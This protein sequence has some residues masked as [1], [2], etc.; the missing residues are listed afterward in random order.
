MPLLKRPKPIVVESRRSTVETFVRNDDKTHKF[1]TTRRHPIYYMAITKCGST[2][3]KNLAYV[4]DHDAPHEN[5][6][7]IHDYNQDLI[8]TDKQN[9][10]DM[11]QEIATDCGLDLSR[12]LTVEAHQQNCE[13]F[14]RWIE[15]NLR[16]DTDIEINPHWRPQSNRIAT[17]AH[18]SLTFLT[19]DGLDWQL[20]LYL[21]DMIPDLPAKMAMAKSRNKTQ[22]PVDPKEIMTPALERQI[23]EVYTDD[24][25]HYQH[26]SRSWKAR[27]KVQTSP[28]PDAPMM[29]VLTTHSQN[30][31]LI[32]LQKAGCT[33]LR[34]LTYQIDH[35][36]PHP[37]PSLIASDGC[38]AYQ[39]KTR[40]QM[41]GGVNVIVLRNPYARFFSLYFD[42]VWGEGQQAFPWI[43]A[44]ISK[45]RRFKKAREL[46][47]AEHHDN[48]CRVLGYLQQR[49]DERPEEDFC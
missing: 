30:F 35:G 28:E 31:N 20:P 33:Y 48:C 11:R 22:Y 16:G 47:Q 37:D 24:L 19:L 29:N 1:I 45:N 14:L 6:D 3:L 39:S 43:A 27:R 44:Q 36:R 15:K 10:P 26:I 32:A 42:K 7:Y 25:V 21:G 13:R 41:R 38:L 2:F 34:N 40:R 4:L 8:R 23:N 17:V 5:P 49:F 9:F 18:L 12:N 46:S